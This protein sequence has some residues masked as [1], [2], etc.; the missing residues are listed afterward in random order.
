ME[1]CYIV[2]LLSI[3]IIISSEGIVSHLHIF[4]ARRKTVESTIKVVTN[5]DAITMFCVLVLSRERS[6]GLAL[7]IS[8]VK[9]VG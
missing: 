9:H 3:E 1:K 5:H 6:T 2:F 4:H 7:F 8:T